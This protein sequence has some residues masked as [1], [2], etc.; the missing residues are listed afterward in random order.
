MTEDLDFVAEDSESIIMRILDLQTKVTF[1]QEKQGVIQRH[2]CKVDK[3]VAA[4]END[5]HAH[6]AKLKDLDH[7]VKNE[8]S[9]LL[10]RLSRLKLLKYD[11][12]DVRSSNHDMALLI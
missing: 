2:I 9:S 10:N 3:E 7:R 4:F 6:T 12:Q 11:F 1:N 8:Q 5:L